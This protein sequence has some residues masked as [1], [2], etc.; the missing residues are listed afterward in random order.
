MAGVEEWWLW[1]SKEDWFACGP[2]LEPY[3]DTFRAHIL[4]AGL[5]QKV[6]EVEHQA[7]RICPAW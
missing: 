7:V 6:Y 2:L 4:V 3:Q 1:N 5:N